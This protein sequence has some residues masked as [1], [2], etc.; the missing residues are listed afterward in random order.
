LISRPGFPGDFLSNFSLITNLWLI[1]SLYGLEIKNNIVDIWT[2]IK[3]GAGMRKKWMVAISLALGLVVVG[4]AGCAFGTTEGV[5]TSGLRV[6]LNGQSEG[7]WVNGQGEVTVVP[8]VAN[9]RVGVEAQEASVTE[10]RDKASSAMLNLT[11]ALNDGGVDKDDIQTQ[12]FNIQQVT[13]WDQDSEQEIVIGYRV[14]NV[15]LAKIRDMEKVGAIIDA[16]AAAGGDLTRI[17]SISFSIDEP[18][19]YYEEARGKA[20][21]DARAK[22]EQLAELGGVKLGKPTYISE[23]TSSPIYQRDVLEKVAGAPAQV[24]TPISPGEMKISLNVQVV[25]DILN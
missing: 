6:N 14:S 7:I 8:D 23:S 20:M 21:K 25:Y 22:G 9:L 3:R 15:V 17:D 4:L 2:T 11:E 1:F 12:Y 18:E 19:K 10:A 16:A 13:R 5:S 24:E